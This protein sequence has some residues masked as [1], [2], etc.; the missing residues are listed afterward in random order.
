MV[1][2]CRNEIKNALPAMVSKGRLGATGARTRNE[3]TCL[4]H[5]DL[6][7]MQGRIIITFYLFTEYLQLII[8]AA[9]SIILSHSIFTVHSHTD[10]Y[11]Q[12]QANT[13]NLHFAIY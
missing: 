6:I 1:E 10:G 9:D 13:F 3:K 2:V 7:H 12:T 5:K 11:R 8:T 4:S